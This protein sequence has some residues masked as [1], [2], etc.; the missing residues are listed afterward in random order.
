MQRMPDDRSMRGGRA[1][2]QEPPGR[3]G[4]A[5]TA[6]FSDG[7]EPL[8]G[9]DAPWNVSGFSGFSNYQAC[10]DCENSNPTVAMTNGGPQTLSLAD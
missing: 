9:A 8:L 7:Q 10:L 4:R 2:L 3:A 6:E 5:R 1:W